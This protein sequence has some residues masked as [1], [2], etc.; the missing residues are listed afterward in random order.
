MGLIKD[1]K[2]IQPNNP[3]NITKEDLIGTLK[4]FPLGIV[5]RMLEET[6]LQGNK[7]DVKIFQNSRSVDS[8]HNGFDWRGTEAGNHFWHVVINYH[9][10]DEFY[11]RYPDYKKYDY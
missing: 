8:M 7:P 10:F 9:G 5:I 11:K 3:F 4:G 6:E 1:I 2:D